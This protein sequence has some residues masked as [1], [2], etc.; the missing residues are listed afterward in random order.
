MDPSRLAS[1]RAPC[2]S[3]E[4][5][6]SS[7]LSSFGFPVEDETSSDRTWQALGVCCNL[8]RG[9]FT[10][11][12]RKLPPQSASDLSP[13]PPHSQDGKHLDGAFTMGLFRMP[14]WWDTVLS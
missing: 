8:P 6:P 2:A 4:F 12:P 11:K 10:P 1:P 5:R 7:R 3:P 13:L 14:R 9:P